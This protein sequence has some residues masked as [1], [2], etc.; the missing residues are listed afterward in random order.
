MNRSRSPSV[1]AGME[2]R[3]K[4]TRSG[5][6]AALRDRREPTPEQRAANAAYLKEWRR[7]CHQINRRPWAERREAPGTGP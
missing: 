4:P 2:T 3:D 5:Y 1:S 7:P 6:Q